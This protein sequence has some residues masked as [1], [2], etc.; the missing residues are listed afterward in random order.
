MLEWRQRKARKEESQR[1]GKANCRTQR[2]QRTKGTEE[3]RKKQK[4]RRAGLGKVMKGRRQKQS[5]GGKEE[6]GKAVQMVG[7]GEKEK[8]V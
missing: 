4:A 2:C 1:E 8:G 6:L 5:E 7:D 3:S